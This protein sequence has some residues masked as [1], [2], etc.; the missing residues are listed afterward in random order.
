MK[1][2]SAKDL[3]WALKQMRLNQG[4]KQ[5]GLAEKA[6]ITKGAL[7]KIESGKRMPGAT[8]L[9]WLLSALDV[10]YKDLVNLV[11]RETEKEM[12]VLLKIKK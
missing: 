7:S 10:Q 1:S 5:T 11:E 9:S 4:Y 6:G 2:L 12:R 3:G 8:T